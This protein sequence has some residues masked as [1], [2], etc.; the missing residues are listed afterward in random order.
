MNVIK[1]N[2]KTKQMKTILSLLA[3]A[4]YTL[5]VSCGS[6][7]SDIQSMIDKYCEL[8]T[9]EHNAT[10]G[11]EKEAATAEKKKYEKEVDGTYFKEYE[12]YQRILKGMKKCDEMIGGDEPLGVAATN[13]T[14]TDLS[15]AY[16]D[17]VAAANKY[18]SLIDK[19]IAAAHNGTDAKLKK[20]VAAKLMFE[21][22][23]EDSYKDNT[24][25]R[26]SI[27]NL[28]KPCLEKEVKARYQ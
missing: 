14:A 18:C 8:N 19:S 22:N 24:E 25:R 10:A 9:K 17:A 21:H 15:G 16:G 3:I 4:L 5:L 27:L 12:T 7:S 2:P 11:A 20:I 28:I 1:I 23:M 6:N 26:D 13:D